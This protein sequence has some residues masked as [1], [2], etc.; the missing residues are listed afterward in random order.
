VVGGWW[1]C[2]LVLWVRPR[3][4]WFELVLEEKLSQTRPLI[5]PRGVIPFDV[6]RL[7]SRSPCLPLLL[8]LLCLIFPFPSL[9]SPFSSCPSLLPFLSCPS[10]PVL[11][12]L[13]LFL[14]S[15]CP[16]LS[17]PVPVPVQ[18]LFCPVPVQF[19]FLSR[20]VLSCPVCPVLSCLSCPSIRPYMAVVYWRKYY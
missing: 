5:I 1:W 17:C 3:R 19:L 8:S 20:P 4:Y 6:A 13:V 2:W 10:C 14:F 7:L 11:S 18:F 15:S 9:N 16:V 12:C